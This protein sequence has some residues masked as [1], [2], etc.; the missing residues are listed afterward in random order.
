[1][2]RPG[3]SAQRLLLLD[4]V[5]EA[6]RSPRGSDEERI[7][8][9]GEQLLTSRWRSGPARPPGW[10]PISAYGPTFKCPGL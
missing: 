7:L 2:K 5:Y 10:L 6:A 9:R 8:A 1:M 3:T 4:W